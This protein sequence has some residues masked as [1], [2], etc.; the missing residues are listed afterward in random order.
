MP[1]VR[2]G[3]H[4]SRKQTRSEAGNFSFLQRKDDGLRDEIETV[5][6]SVSKSSALL[7]V[8]MAGVSGAVGRRQ[9]KRY[10]KR[11]TLLLSGTLVGL[12]FT[13]GPVLHSNYSREI[14]HTSISPAKKY[15]LR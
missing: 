2:G 5:A 12:L 7:L 9:S 15:V 14:N 1:S 11:V 6:S 4:E 13:A 8:P 3:N 10:L